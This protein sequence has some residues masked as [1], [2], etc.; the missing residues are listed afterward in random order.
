MFLCPCVFSGNE[1][2]NLEDSNY[3]YGSLPPIILA[4][5][6]NLLPEMGKQNNKKKLKHDFSRCVKVLYSTKCLGS[7]P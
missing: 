3:I 5:Q 7:E 1:K 4:T 6:Y 2:T